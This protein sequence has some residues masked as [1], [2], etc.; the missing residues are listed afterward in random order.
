MYRTS[1]DCPQSCLAVSMSWHSSE[2]TQQKV[3]Q[4]VLIAASLLWWTE[5]TT[6]WMPFQR[7]VSNLTTLPQSRTVTNELTVF[8]CEIVCKI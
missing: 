6:A 3:K 7:K 4:W 5:P 8:T 1:L 2:V